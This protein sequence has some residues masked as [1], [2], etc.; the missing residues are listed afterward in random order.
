VAQ[1]QPRIDLDEH[2]LPALLVPLE[3]YGAGSRIGR[4]PAIAFRQMVQLGDIVR[5]A[6]RDR[7][8]IRGMLP[9]L[10]VH[11]C[12]GYCPVTVVYKAH[13]DEIVV[14]ARDEPLNAVV[15]P[16]SLHPETVLSQLTLV[17]G[18]NRLAAE[19]P[20]KLDGI[21]ECPADKREARH[22]RLDHGRIVVPA[23]DIRAADGR[24]Q[25]A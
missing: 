4:L 21:D 18:S 22:R 20:R 7:S 8:E 6:D 11:E 15:D 3:L 16:L 9:E 14:T 17:A 25:C 13:H 10:P 23:L 1:A 2:P 24:K 5:R 19:P 12:G